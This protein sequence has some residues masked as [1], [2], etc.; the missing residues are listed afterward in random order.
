MYIHSTSVRPLEA[1]TMDSYRSSESKKS[2]FSLVNRQNLIF[3]NLLA[4][5][6]YKN[7]FLY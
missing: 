7:K 3:I 6:P 5:S 4:I 2:T 1:I